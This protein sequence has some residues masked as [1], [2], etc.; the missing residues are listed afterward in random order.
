MLLVVA[1][2]E[3]FKSDFS[4][5]FGWFVREAGENVAWRFQSAME[6]ALD[7]LALLPD[8][9]AFCRFRNPILRELRSFR[10]EPPFHKI[11]IF[12]RVRDE[13]L[14][15]WRLMHGARQLSRRL[16]ESPSAN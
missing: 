1:K 16:L 13:A 4:K 14:E 12:Y 15:A 5:Y 6:T 7:R 10:V 3:E 8:L 11:L 2:S 9:G